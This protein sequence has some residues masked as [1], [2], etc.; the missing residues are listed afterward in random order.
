LWAFSGKTIKG[1]EKMT[2]FIYRPNSNL[3]PLDTLREYLENNYTS[4]LEDVYYALDEEVSDL[5]DSLEELDGIE[6]ELETSE[7]TLNDLKEELHDLIKDF[8][9]LD[10]KEIKEELERILF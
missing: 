9:I 2:P 3:I 5:E 6:E 4:E 1:A 8:K 10:K 7:K